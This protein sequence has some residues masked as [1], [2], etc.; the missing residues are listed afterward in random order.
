MTN[1][2]SQVYV[3]NNKIPVVQRYFVNTDSPVGFKLDTQYVETNVK[4]INTDIIEVGIL[5]GDSLE[6][7]EFKEGITYCGFHIK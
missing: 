2:V 6:Y 1:F 3:G 4:E 5:N 7:V